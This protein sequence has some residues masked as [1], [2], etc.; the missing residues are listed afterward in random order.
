MRINARHDWRRAGGHTVVVLLSLLCACDPMVHYMVTRRAAVGADCPDATRDFV[1]TRK[2]SCCLD[3]EPQIA[4]GRITF[5]A[6]EDRREVFGAGDIRLKHS[7]YLDVFGGALGSDEVWG[8]LQMT[9]PSTGAVVFDSGEV[10][11]EDGFCE[12]KPY[13]F[14]FDSKCPR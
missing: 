11:R 10:R 9:C 8:R 2:L 6:D 1:I 14:R 12:P 13:S 3:R 5:G 4:R 7:E